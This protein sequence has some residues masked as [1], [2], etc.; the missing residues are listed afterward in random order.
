MDISPPKALLFGYPKKI[1][2]NSEKADNANSLM[3]A[4]KRLVKLISSL[5][6]K[7]RDVCYHLC[8][9]QIMSASR[10]RLENKEFTVLYARNSWI[11][12]VCFSHFEDNWKFWVKKTYILY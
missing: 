5:A 7:F 9:H 3:Y 11:G 2:V 1:N 4:F 10:I 8:D 6:K 12:D